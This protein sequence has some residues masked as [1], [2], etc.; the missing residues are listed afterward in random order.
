MLVITCH[1]SIIQNNTD[2]KFS[3]VGYSDNEEFVSFFYK[4]GVLCYVAVN[5]DIAE[6]GQFCFTLPLFN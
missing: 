4:P 2:L 3:R 5:I 1:G 6:V